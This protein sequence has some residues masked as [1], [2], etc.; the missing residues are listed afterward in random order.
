MKTCNNCLV[1][2]PKDEF[3][4][5]NTS[6]DK[7]SWWCRDC[8]KAYVKRK[9]AQN[10]ADK[11]FAA[12]E[13]ARVAIYFRKH[14]EKHKWPTGAKALANAKKYR[15]G[16][17]NR[18]PA[19]L[20]EDDFWIME[21]AYELARLRTAMFGFQWEVDHELPLRGALVSGLHV[22]DNLKVIPKLFNRSKSNR[23]AVA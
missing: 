11:D 9:Y 1:A 23:F 7:L 15:H 19:W 2:K 17:D 18:T 14:P 13:I 21:Q 16:K 12:K 4:K 8:H 3:Y 20:T 6:K 22:P 5:K 10:Y